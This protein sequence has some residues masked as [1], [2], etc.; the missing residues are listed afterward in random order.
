MKSATE[1][2]VA[3]VCDLH[4]YLP[5]SDRCKKWYAV[6]TTSW[7]SCLQLMVDMLIILFETLY[8]FS[9]NYYDPAKQ[10]VV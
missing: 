6:R 5:I 7:N 2:E 4:E 1:N 8:N 3:D 9:D 10:Y